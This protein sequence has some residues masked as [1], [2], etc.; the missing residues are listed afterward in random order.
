MRRR[1]PEPYLSGQA[2]LEKLNRQLK[3]G[4]LSRD[5]ALK[6][7]GA[8]PWFLEHPELPPP[9]NQMK[10]S[11]ADEQGRKYAFPADQENVA[12]VKLDKAPPR[13][14]GYREVNLPRPGEVITL[15][16][17]RQFSIGSVLLGENRMT[18]AALTITW[19]GK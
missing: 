12:H 13:F 16:D 17:G 19:L 2:R 8:N 6:I 4:E 1:I 5:Q 14:T 3:S 10:T 15:E 7:F 18:S 9:A 11:A